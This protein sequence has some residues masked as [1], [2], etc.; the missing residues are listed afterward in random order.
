[1]ARSGKGSVYLYRTKEATSEWE[2]VQI[3]RPNVEAGPSGNFGQ[4][5]ALDDGS[6]TLVVGAPNEGNNGVAFVFKRASDN[7]W[8]QFGDSL[9]IGQ[10]GD[11]FGFR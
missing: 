11:E 3:L 7:T 4:S 5:I 9:T 1:M 2:L 6:G 10:F 8:S